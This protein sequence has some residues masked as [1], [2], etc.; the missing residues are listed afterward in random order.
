VAKSRDVQTCDQIGRQLS[1]RRSVVR[2][3][4]CMRSDESLLKAAAAGDSYAFALFYRRYVNELVAY[5]RRRVPTPEQAF[6]LTAETFAIVAL[7]PGEFRGDGPAVAWLFGIARNVLRSSL[8]RRRIEDAAR[9][10][11]GAEPTP[12]TDADLQAVE[13][14]AAAGQRGLDA[15]LETLPDPMRRALLARVVEER[16]YS[17]I[18]SELECSEQLVRQRVRRGLARL[19]A[20]V[21]EEL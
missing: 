16:E 5:F 20:Q 11:L 7:S 10:R 17:D 9:R 1:Q 21:K 4:L 18:A 2:R 8:R 14:R 13:D 3:Y 12:M 15:A 19:R 6:D